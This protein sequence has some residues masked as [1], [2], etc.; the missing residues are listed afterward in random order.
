MQ[1]PHDERAGTRPEPDGDFLLQA[2]GPN[3]LIRM[4]GD[5]DEEEQRFLRELP[6]VTDNTIVV[7]APSVLRTG[8]L[9]PLLWEACRFGL[10]ESRGPGHQLWL[11]VPELGDVEGPHAR[12]AAELSSAFRVDIVAPEADV[13]WVAGGH[14]YA[15]GAAG[16]SGWRFFRGR[17]PTFRFAV[18]WRRPYWEALVPPG[19]TTTDELQADPIPAGLYVRSRSG[20]PLPEHAGRQVRLSDAAPR[21]VLDLAG[22]LPSPEETAVL[23][24]RLPPG[25]RRYLT[26][27][28]VNG[29]RPL[30]DWASRLAALLDHD[31]VL[32]SVSLI[33]GRDGSW[34]P[35]ALPDLADLDAHDQLSLRCH[36]PLGRPRVVERLAVSDLLV[37]PE[38][39][40]PAET[41]C[42]GA[43]EQTV[44]LPVVGAPA[45]PRFAPGGTAPVL[46]GA[47][48]DGGAAGDAEWADGES[49]QEDASGAAGASGPG[50]PAGEPHPD[51]EASPARAAVA[52]EEGVTPRPAVVPSGDDEANLPRGTTSPELG[53]A[54]PPEAE[55]ADGGMPGAEGGASGS[56]QPPRAEESAGREESPHPGAAPLG[57]E[58]SRDDSA[59]TGAATSE[60][61]WT[62]PEDGRAGGGDPVPSEERAATD[63]APAEPPSEQ[64]G[65]GDVPPR[66]SPTEPTWSAEPTPATDGAAADAGVG[67]DDEHP[68]HRPTS[69][70]LWWVRH[71]PEHPARNDRPVAPA[72]TMAPPPGTDHVSNGAPRPGGIANRPVTESRDGATRPGDPEVD[73]REPVTGHT[74]PATD[75]VDAATEPA[76]DRRLRH[77]GTPTP[78]GTRDEP[79][80]SDVEAG[81]VR[82]DARP[83]APGHE[84]TSPARPSEGRST[85]EGAD[86]PSTPPAAG[87]ADTPPARADEAPAGDADQDRAL[88]R[89]PAAGEP[90]RGAHPGTEATTAARDRVPGTHR[91]GDG[92]DGGEPRDRRQADGDRSVGPAADLPALPPT[93][94]RPVDHSTV[95][96]AASP[97]PSSDSD[98]DSD[99]HLD[100]A[101]WAT[102]REAEVSPESPGPVA[103]GGSE[104]AATPDGGAR[105]DGGEA[106]PRAVDQPGTRP[107]DIDEHPRPEVAGDVT[108]ATDETAIPPEAPSPGHLDA[109]GGPREDHQDPGAAPVA[110]APPAPPADG[111]IAH[112][113]AVPEDQPPVPEADAGGAD[114]PPAPV[115]A[116]PPVEPAVVPLVPVRPATVAEP[117]PADLTTPPAGRH[118]PADPP[119]EARDVPP[120]P[121]EPPAAAPREP[122]PHPTPPP[123]PTTSSTPG[124]WDLTFYAEEP[125]PSETSPATEQPSTVEQTPTVDATEGPVGEPA[126]PGAESEDPATEPAGTEGAPSTED[127]DDPEPAPGD[128]GDR[129]GSEEDTGEEDPNGEAAVGWVPPDHRSTEAERAALARLVGEDYENALAT[130]NAALA[131]SPVLRGAGGESAKADFVAV[132]LYLAHEGY[133]GRVL[134]EALRSDGGRGWRDLV[135]CLTSGLR[136][137][138]V[139]RGATFQQA[140]LPDDGDRLRE[141]CP[142]AEVLD[143]PGFLSATAAHDLNT[144]DATVD[145]LIWSTTGRRVGMLGAGGL[146]EEV[147]FFSH[148]RFKVLDVVGGAATRPAVLAR[149]LRANETSLGIG[150]DEVDAQVLARLRRALGRRQRATPRELSEEETFGRWAA[151]FGLTGS[152]MPSSSSTTTATAT[153]T[154]GSAD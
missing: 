8:N 135:A 65:P 126:A 48:S 72:A 11:A 83:A 111:G 105:E 19:P 116:A 10:P 49:D 132:C 5:R 91:A 74:A 143:E 115:E 51:D 122:A 136:R 23:V 84:G 101:T 79:S 45:A 38:V 20:Q 9:W 106:E 2:R 33:R 96:A 14:L 129:S 82:V 3:V 47:A 16:E 32:P 76:T 69:A 61:A 34:R 62:A 41:D 99:S 28:P 123:G 70:P 46:G 124:R 137:L 145:L 119:P 152:A 26:V 29:V 131:M 54:P 12:W 88:T 50:T 68:G 104:A 142:P 55:E 121:A 22:G 151:P 97:T 112:P 149:E 59:P 1:P 17:Q 141:V 140:H 64:D 27:V 37:D 52:E 148:S 13:E 60:A 114:A 7:V 80:T 44:V 120:P 4:A 150:L 139:H 95:D 138:P 81:P 30:S 42:P 113:T 144:P 127:T 133:G 78:T 53:A 6:A 153:A 18:R 147:V 128:E 56:G 117:K 73:P 92:P 87:P 107:A 67:V 39:E 31:V 130:V 125:P 110:G 77:G 35:A 21:V 75:E 154:A 103:G 89:E 100:R 15:G 94:P 109:H 57:R 71:D 43:N 118:R 98:S 63:T 134:N 108:G 146:P 40:V 85:P 66:P 25:L 102:D 24:D 93:E 86:D 90:D 36:P 58:E